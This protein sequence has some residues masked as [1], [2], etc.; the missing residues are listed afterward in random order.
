M[1]VCDGYMDCRDASDEINCQGNVFVHLKI[2]Q[3][4]FKWVELDE[5]E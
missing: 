2:R 4:Q 3:I 1:Y 5:S